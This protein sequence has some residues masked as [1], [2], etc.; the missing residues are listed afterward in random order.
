MDAGGGESV[1][2]KMRRSKLGYY[3]RSKRWRENFLGGR[4]GVFAGGLHCEEKNMGLYSST[5]Q[6]N[7]FQ[8]DQKKKNLGRGKPASLRTKKKIHM[9]SK[10]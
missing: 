6:E 5:T 1:L 4:G 2:I 8:A 7:R 3:H 9:G 10:K